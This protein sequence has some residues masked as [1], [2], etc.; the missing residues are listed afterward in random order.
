MSTAEPKFVAARLCVIIGRVTLILPC[1]GAI[2][3][4]LFM[5]TW[6][7]SIRG[8]LSIYNF[9]IFICCGRPIEYNRVDTISNEI[10]DE[11][12]FID[13]TEL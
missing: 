7:K 10:K 2:Y 12:W 6:S 9:R 13:I 11:N 1:P 3:Y 8:Q 5:K 4:R